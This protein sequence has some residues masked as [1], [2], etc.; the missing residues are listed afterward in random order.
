MHCYTV[1]L[2]KK[3]ERIRKK[4]RRKTPYP[5][6]LC[7]NNINSPNI[8]FI[9]ACS[10]QVGHENEKNNLRTSHL[11]KFFGDYN[12]CAG[13]NDFTLKKTAAFKP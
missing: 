5:L 13:T 9:V 8:C 6:Q 4:K 12:V 3:H 1:N 11:Q 7:Q 2:K 10:I